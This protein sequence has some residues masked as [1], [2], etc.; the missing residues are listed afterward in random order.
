MENAVPK[1][2]VL[3]VTPTQLKELRLLKIAV[4]HPDDSDGRLLIQQLQRIG[5][6]VQAYWPPLQTMQD[7]VEVV[8]MAVQPEFINAKFNWTQGDNAPTIIAIVS[9]ENPTIIEAVLNIGAN[10]IL[11]SPVRSFGL[12][13]TMV[14]ARETHK[15]I[16]LLANRVRKL[17]AKLVGQRQIS[18]AKVIL[19]KAHGISEGKAYDLIRDQ[20]MTKR[21]TVEEIAVA[22]VTANDILAPASYSSKL[23]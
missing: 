5:C 10:A 14:M 20:A 11:A 6:Q 9:Y 17:E 3:R 18:D 23:V 15:H 4:I 8:F 2:Q 16:R 13:S 12:L 1:R 21:I 19:M 22:I 7:N